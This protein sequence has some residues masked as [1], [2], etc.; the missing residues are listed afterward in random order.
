MSSILLVG[1]PNI[2]NEMFESEDVKVGF[3]FLV[4]FIA[5]LVAIAGGVNLN[6]Y[7]DNQKVQSCIK[8]DRIWAEGACVNNV[9]EL[10]YVDND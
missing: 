10:R 3:L 9:N 8:A 1:T 6:T 2:R 7:L 4:G 5:L